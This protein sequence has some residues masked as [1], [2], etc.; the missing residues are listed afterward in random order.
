MSDSLLKVRDLSVTFGSTARGTS[1]VR[2]VSFDV[3]AGEVVGIVGESGSGKSVTCRAILG[4]LPE[5]AEVTGQVEYNGNDLLSMDSE[6]LRQ[7]RGRDVS[8]VFQNPASHLDPLMAVGMQVAE[9][10]IHHQNASAAQAREAAIQRLREVQLDRP[11]QR[12]DNYP[13][14]LS[15]GM[16]QR[17]M[18]AAAIACDP[19]LL[20]ADEPTTAL[21]V[22]VQSRVL[23]LLKTLNQQ[24]QLSIVLVSHDLAVV[25]QVCDRV[26]VMRH[27]EIIEHGSTAQIIDTPQHPYT[28]QLIESQP[29]RMTMRPESSI[30]GQVPLDVID[31]DVEFDLPGRR[32]LRALDGVSI[33][34]RKASR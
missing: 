12:V 9:P 5:T 22:T 33:Q 28:Q 29:S 3:A 31:V 24:H 13:H 6:G 18:I 8:M 27:G 1:A 4:L 21:D 2:N 11:E 20:L 25:A 34:L 30:D 17:V 19:G 32:K 14:Q 26:L 10:L 7:V 16:K 15:G 23:E